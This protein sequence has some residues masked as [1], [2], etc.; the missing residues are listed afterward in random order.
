MSPEAVR[1]IPDLMNLCITFFFKVQRD[2]RGT[3][4]FCC[5]KGFSS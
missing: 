5:S 3:L 2:S 1:G 4:E